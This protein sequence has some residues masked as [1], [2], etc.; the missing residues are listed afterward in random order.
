LRFLL[1]ANGSLRLYGPAYAVSQSIA[2]RL[3]FACFLAVLF[4]SLVHCFSIRGFSLA[5]RL[6]CLAFLLVCEFVQL[7]G[8]IDSR[9]LFPAA[10]SCNTTPSDSACASTLQP[11]VLCG[12]TVQPM[13]FPNLLPSG[14]ILPVSLR[15][16]FS[17]S[18]VHCFSIRGF[19][20]L[21]GFLTWPF[22]VYKF[23][24]L[25]GCHIDNFLGI[26]VHSTSGSPLRVEFEKCSECGL[27]RI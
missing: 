26:A 22:L 2:F 17:R 23:V 11:M 6:P 25:I 27:S 5:L 16:L 4:L 3:H 18:L 7:T 15:L 24:P 14:S 13:Q 1:A 8:T 9:S 12:F 19:L 20:G 10:L 21:C